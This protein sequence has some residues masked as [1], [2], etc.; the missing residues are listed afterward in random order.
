M[1][2][3]YCRRIA[4][5]VTNLET[6]VVTDLL[7]DAMA[8]LV[9]TYVDYV[10]CAAIMSACIS[11]FGVYIVIGSKIGVRTIVRGNIT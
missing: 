5:F 2:L 1:S 3:Y 6:F 9:V 4:S 8:V 10:L 11:T 7:V